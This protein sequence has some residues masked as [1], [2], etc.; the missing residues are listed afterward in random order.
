M[1]AKE[2]WKKGQK[3]HK[4]GW[5]LLGFKSGGYYVYPSEKLLNDL[6]ED[7]TSV[8]EKKNH[9][10]V[11]APLPNPTPLTLLPKP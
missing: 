1:V 7:V 5:A 8:A 2:D 3:L 10:K 11:T 6:P 9:I 4:K